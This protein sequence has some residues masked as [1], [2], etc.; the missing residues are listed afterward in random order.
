MVKMD[1]DM[2]KSAVPLLAVFLL[3]STNFALAWGGAGHMTIAAEAFR[4]LSPELKAQAFEVLKAHPDYAQ[5][6]KAYRPNPNYDLAAYVFMRSSTWPDEIRR[7]GNPYDHPDWHFIDYPLR[8]P[9]FPLLRDARPTDNVLYGIAQ[10]QKTLSDTNANPEQRAVYLSY[11]IH[12]IGDMHQPLHCCSL[13]T[14]AYPDGDRGGNDFFVKPALHGIRLHGIWD[15]LL[16]TS[17]NPQTQ[18]KYALKLDA[19]FPR[20]DL[21]ELFEHTTPLQWSLESRQLAIDKGYLHGDL[22]G[23]KDADSACPLPAGYLAAAKAVAERQ[24]ALAGYRLADQIQACLKWANPVPLLPENTVTT[25]QNL[26]AKIGAMDADKYYDESM[27]VT[28][29][30]VDVSLRSTVAILDLDKP[31]PASPCTAVIFEDNMDQFGDLQ[32]FQNRDVEINGDITEYHDHPEII[33]ESTN[34]I[35]IVQ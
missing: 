9:S 23:G 20:T 12:L 26:P 4:Q 3:L 7:S 19:E 18:W 28:G 17:M 6:V 16:G 13:F 34:Q 22:K 2:R 24:G 32:R 10:C 33:L 27:V 31:Y 30:V 15:G 1:E 8:P 35:K 25:A 5:W 14:D 11:L 21:P 29:R